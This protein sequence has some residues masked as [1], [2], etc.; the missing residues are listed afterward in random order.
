MHLYLH[1]PFCESKCHYCAF[2][3]LA[4]NKLEKP[5][6]SALLEDIKAQIQNFNTQKQSI[7]TL[8][9][10]GGTPSVIKACFYE[11]IFEFLQPFLAPNAELTSEAN[12]NSADKNWLKTMK[13]FGLNRISFGVQSF[14]EKKL[15]FLGRIHRFK[16]VLDALENANCVGFKNINI[17]MIYDTKMDT[18]KML[19]FELANLNSLKKLFTHISAYHLTI[20]K[21]TA[22]SKKLH[23]KKNASNLMKYFIKNIENLGLRQYEIS[24]FGKKCQH[25]LAYWQGKNYIGCG[26]SSVGF[27]DDRRFYTKANL[28]SYIKEPCFRKIEPL[29]KEDLHLE[30]LFLG[31]RSCVGIDEKKLSQNELEKALFLS[32]K[33]K[34]IYKNHRFFNTNFLLS[35]EIV[36]FLQN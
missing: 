1:I 16:E 5:Y 2:T 14:N 23:Y 26:L 9:I 35:D 3:S 8:F 36:L 33:K 29:S 18:K 4:T 34:L 7:Q 31:L 32:E 6:M 13:S 22:F 21:N 25:N 27:K 15:H 11:P 30:H 17:D 20:E 12:P 28:Q 10:G 24:N 19:D